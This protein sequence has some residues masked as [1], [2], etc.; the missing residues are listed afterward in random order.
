[1]KVNDAISGLL[2]L[3]LA[4]FAFVEAGSFPVMPGIPYGPDLFP[5]IVAS[6]MGLG[7]VLLILSGARDLLHE[8]WVDLA[9]WAR[10]PRSW[11]VFCAV[12]GGMAF[13]I[14][15]AGSLG[16]MLVSFL[17][18]TALMALTRGIARLPS[19]LAVAAAT[20]GAVHAI[21]GTV[22]RVPLPRGPVEALLMGY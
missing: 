17:L 12:T 15:A 7:G 9:P 11:I 13:Y 5:R 10:D 20:T 8:R 1:M 18:L 19:S 2:F 14:L 3:A 4:V 22:L 16:F 21:F 6:V